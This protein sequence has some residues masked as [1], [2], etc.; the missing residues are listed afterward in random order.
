MI[1]NLL[2]EITFLHTTIN[3]D[4]HQRGRDHLRIILLISLLTLHFISLPT[5][6]SSQPKYLCSCI[7]SIIICSLISYPRYNLSVGGAFR[8]ITHRTRLTCCVAGIQ[9]T[10]FHESPLQITLPVTVFQVF[11]TSSFHYRN[12]LAPSVGI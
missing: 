8:K 4:N 5:C 9:V 10:S 6:E 2:S 3:R 11:S 12:S 7:Q 1:I